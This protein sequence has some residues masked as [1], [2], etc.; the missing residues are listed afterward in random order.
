MVVFHIR[1]VPSELKRIF[2]VAPP[3]LN[4]KSRPTTSLRISAEVIAE[5]EPSVVLHPARPTIIPKQANCIKRMSIPMDRM[6]TPKLGYVFA[7][8]SNK[9]LLSFGA[10]CPHLGVASCSMEGRTFFVSVQGQ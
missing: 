4:E 2:P 6:S 5:L 9:I 10:D 8:E 3:L 1:A 7:K